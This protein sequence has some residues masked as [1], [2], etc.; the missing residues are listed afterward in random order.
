MSKLSWTAMGD[1][2][3]ETGCDRGVLFTQG[4]AV[5]WDGLLAVRERPS[6]AEGSSTYVDGIKQRNSLGLEELNLTIEVYTYPD[7]FNACVGSDEAQSGI[8]FSA[9]PRQPFDLAYRTNIGNDVNAELGYKIHF[10]YGCLAMPSE[11][12]YETVSATPSL[13]NFS[14][15]LATKPSL[16]IP[17]TKPSSHLFIDSTLAHPDLMKTLEDILYGTAATAPRMPTPIELGQMFGQWLT[18]VANEDGLTWT[19]YCPDSWITIVGDMFTLEWP[20]AVIVGDNYTIS[21]I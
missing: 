14:W 12:D 10:V 11:Q 1:R 19:A 8:I 2:L 15:D 3:F 16:V 5:A 21:S 13:V 4:S 6:I 9:Q 18:V 17:G 20:N 7:E